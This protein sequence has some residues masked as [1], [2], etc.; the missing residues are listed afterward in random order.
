MKTRTPLSVLLLA[1]AVLL[2]SAASAQSTIPG[3]RQSS[4]EYYEA[5]DGAKQGLLKRERLEPNNPELC[6]VTSYEYDERGNKKKATVTNCAG[7]AADSPAKFEPRESATDFGAADRLQ[8]ITQGAGTAGGGSAT[9][10]KQPLGLIPHTLTNAMG[11]QEQ[12][13]HDPRFGILTRLI[14]PNGLPTS[15]VVDDFGRKLKEL[16]PDNTSTVYWHCLYKADSSGRPQI[17]PENTTNTVHPQG[18]CPDPTDAPIGAVSMVQSASYAADGS[19]QI[20]AFVRVY[21]DRL[22]RT[23]RTVT[24][25]FDGI[26]QPS[27]NLAG[28]IA[29][30]VVY[31]A[32]GATRIQSQPY[33][34][35]TGASVTGSGGGGR[36]Q[37]ETQ[38]D[39]LGRPTRVDTTGVSYQE[40][41][42]AGLETRQKNDK[43]QVRTEVR[44]VSGQVLLITDA[45]GGQLVQQHD[46]FDNLIETRD[47]LKNRVVISYDTRG[48]KIGLKDPDAGLTTYLY[49][50]L[51]ELRW[52][53][54]ANQRAKG[55][56][57]GTEM[58]YDLLGRMIE[59][60][61]QEFTARWSYDRYLDDAAGSSTCNLGKGKLCEAR[62]NLAGGNAGE[63]TNR[64]W[65]YDNLGRPASSSTRLSPNGVVMNT[66]LAYQPNTG[67]LASQTYPSGLQLGYDYTGLGFLHKVQ[68]MTAVTI[69]P[70][71]N[72]QGQTAA[73]VNLG[74]G[75]V[76]WQAKAVNAWGKVEQQAL[77]NGIVNSASFEPATGRILELAAGTVAQARSVQHMA[78]A[79][80]SLGNLRTRT[81]HVGIVDNGVPSG[82]I[83]EV[84]THGDPLNRLT[85]YEVQAAAIAGGARV[86]K[87]Q[88][89]ALGMLLSKSDVG[90]YHYPH[91]GPEAVRPHAIQRLTRLDGQVVSYGHD[92]NGSLVSADGG[93]YRSVGYTSFNLPD[94][95]QGLQGPAGTY[96]WVYDE[97]H[98][99]VSETRVTAQG[100][101][102]T[103]HLHPDNQGGL[104]FERELGPNGE[105]SNRHY[106]SAGGQAFA[107]LVTTGTLVASP[108][109]GL[110]AVKLEYWHKDHLGSLVATTDHQ[111]TVTAR[112]AYDPFGKRRQVNGQYDPFGTLVVDWSAT[113]NHGTDRG[114]TGHEHLDDVGVVHMNGRIFDPELGLF[115]QADPF[116][117]DPTD[118][119]NFNRY[120][121]CLNNPL[122]CTDPSGFFSQKFLKL[123]DPL[124]IKKAI[125]RTNFGYQLGRVA[126][127]VASSWCAWAAP[128]C[129]GA[130]Q[131]AWAGYAGATGTDQERIGWQAGIS[132]AGNLVIGEFTKSGSFSN[133]AA[134]VAWG[135]IEAK[136]SGGNCA[137]GA[138]GAA[139]SELMNKVVPT[140]G[141]PKN[142]YFDRSVNA[143]IRA[144]AGG[145]VSLA[146]GGD[147]GQGARS[148]AYAYLYNWLLHRESVMN[149][150]GW[151]A[152]SF[153]M[154]FSDLD[155]EKSVVGRML[156]GEA[157]VLY[158]L[159][160]RLESLVE[161]LKCWGECFGSRDLSA[162]QRALAVEQLESKLAAK[163]REIV[164]RNEWSMMFLSRDQVITILNAFQEIPYF[165]HFYGSTESIMK[166]FPERPLRG[167][168]APRDPDC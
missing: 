63:S 56:T 128:V 82:A 127:S 78:Y 133:F 107:V 140:Y 45:N 148:A 151:G 18:S 48:R 104:G 138:K 121:Y 6:V 131:A 54:T 11:H 167:T 114:F 17:D 99:R 130:G 122:G 14:G 51:G 163:A 16:R 15:W 72:S 139:V 50:A 9:T 156:A 60:K 43:G 124:G 134:H 152:E 12:R 101:R 41:T 142:N 52:Q 81:D 108:Q 112:Y 95:S 144:A 119:Q 35:A 166:H 115:M 29:T 160:L 27:V 83:S 31:T 91:Q 117:Q 30:D 71:P 110:A 25:G 32:A 7:V 53:Q 98:A 90:N 22:G 141:D 1:L 125:A 23:V 84:F 67:R 157:R 118:L 136:E 55:A 8:A 105:V 80:D 42:Y 103:Y 111:G 86:V 5:S 76:L 44:A 57:V 126:I 145:L 93:K 58:A 59:R 159:A 89:N 150:A 70:L 37:T 155:P 96:T 120:G 161:D 64:R 46:A 154:T 34:L 106:L 19:T 66:Q 62:T 24:Q 13:E 36:G 20:S 162:D 75:S 40:F 158:R 100:T 109:P 21:A 10:V 135:C 74:S 137:D 153:D 92:A 129:N 79:W 4:F 146:S 149:R 3:T 88:Y 85:Q 77:G 102:I 69:S 26:E 47:A 168:C 164:H 61:A 73:G 113:V 132:T 87:L 28:L 123:M 165:R 49:N 94:S 33:F 39:A 116:V 38:Y 97:S 65:V 143:L 2:P 147:F 68:L